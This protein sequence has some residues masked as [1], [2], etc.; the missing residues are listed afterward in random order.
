MIKDFKYAL[1][2]GRSAKF[3][4]QNCGLKHELIDEDVIQ[5][6]SAPK[7]VCQTKIL[8]HKDQ[9]EQEK[10]REAKRIAKKKSKQC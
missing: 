7:K 4:P 5:I 6:F 3:S 10:A 1:V 8:D 2:W 9:L